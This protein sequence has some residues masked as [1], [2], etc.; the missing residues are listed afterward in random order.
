MAASLEQAPTVP[1]PYLKLLIAKLD[2]QHHKSTIKAILA[3]L[4]KVRS[5]RYQTLDRKY[6]QL[7][8]ETEFYSNHYLSLIEGTAAS[9]EQVFREPVI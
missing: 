6:S 8:F 9:N 5:P 7:L 2:S 3:L 1:Y 4:P